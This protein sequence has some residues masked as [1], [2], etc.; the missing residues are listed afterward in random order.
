[1]FG[2]IIKL[3]NPDQVPIKAGGILSDSEP[4][5][6]QSQNNKQDMFQYC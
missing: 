4:F 5:L 6:V 3:L 1:M 2:F